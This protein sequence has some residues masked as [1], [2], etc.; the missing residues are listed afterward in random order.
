MDE[1]TTLG[2]NLLHNIETVKTK[3]VDLVHTARQHTHIFV[4]IVI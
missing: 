3:W 1:L 2:W 4:N